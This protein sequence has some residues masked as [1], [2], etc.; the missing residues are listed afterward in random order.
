MEPKTFTAV[1]ASWSPSSTSKVVNHDVVFHFI[2]KASPDGNALDE[3]ARYK[4]VNLGDEA[5]FRE[6]PDRVSHW[7]FVDHYQ[8]ECSRLELY[9]P[10][11]GDDQGLPPDTSL[12]EIAMSANR[13]IPLA[14]VD[15]RED[16]PLSIEQ[17]VSEAPPQIEE[18]YARYG[19][20]LSLHKV[21]FAKKMESTLKG[22]YFINQHTSED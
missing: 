19:I 17:L 8:V 12:Y 3:S 1:T 9:A 7:R 18:I 16:F 15:S 13:E 2:L 22:S 14:K 10:E 21:T 5:L 4:A 20:S 6:L 11:Y